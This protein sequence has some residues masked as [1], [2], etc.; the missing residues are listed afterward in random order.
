MSTTTNTTEVLKGYPNFYVSRIYFEALIEAS[1][2][3]KEHFQDKVFPE[4]TLMD[5][6]KKAIGPM[7]TINATLTSNEINSIQLQYHK[8][9]YLFLRRALSFSR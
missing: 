1:K 7:P 3:I 4:E 2:F 6:V 9:E 8:A 5:I